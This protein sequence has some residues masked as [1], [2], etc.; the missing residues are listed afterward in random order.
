MITK[1]REP[2]GIC[3]VPDEMAVEIGRSVVPPR[4][5]SFSEGALRDVHPA[6]CLADGGMVAGAQARSHV[7]PRRH[8]I[9]YQA[10]PLLRREARIRSTPEA[11]AHHEIPTVRRDRML[12]A[13]R[14]ARC[15]HRLNGPVLVS[16]P[17][18]VGR[19]NGPR[20]LLAEN[21]L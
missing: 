14:N 8:E 21:P 4:R 9:G 6:A 12:L 5:A 13:R 20:Y 19:M 10:I 17:Q 16:D 7:T 2:V 18:R 1:S 3:G 15:H 11:P